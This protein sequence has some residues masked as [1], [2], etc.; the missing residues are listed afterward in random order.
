MTRGIFIAGNESALCRAVEAET[1]SKVE[2]YAAALIPNRLSGAPKNSPQEMAQ[3]L[4]LDWNPSSPISAR[5]LVLAAENRLERIDEAILICSPPSIRSS[6]SEIPI[7]DVEIMINDHI[8]GWFFLAKEIAALF[9]SRKRGTL[10]LVF[11]DIAGASKDDSADVL[12]PSAL[13][14][15]RALTYGLLSAAHNEAYATVGFSTSDAGNE[16][17]FA[18]FIFKTMDEISNRSNGKLHKFGKFSLFK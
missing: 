14:S 10:A 9:S 18:A 3:R 6:A 16:S 11:P 15:F 12:G 5:T 8:K 13:A 1:V 7:S 17:A 4:S 2:Q